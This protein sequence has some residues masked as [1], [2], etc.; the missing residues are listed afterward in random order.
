MQYASILQRLIHQRMDIGLMQ[1]QNTSRQLLNGLCKNFVNLACCPSA[2]EKSHTKVFTPILV[3]WL[4]CIGRC[5]FVII[6]I[7]SLFVCLYTKKLYEKIFQ[8]KSHTNS[9][10]RRAPQRN[11]VWIIW[12]WRRKW[13]K[14]SSRMTID[15]L[16]TNCVV[17]GI[18]GRRSI[19]Y[20]YS[21]MC[22]FVL[23][24]SPGVHFDQDDDKHGQDE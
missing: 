7:W 14:G 15:F 9:T 23:R 2:S 3:L 20:V 17:S 13:S 4:F 21:S 12:S 10:T 24:V 11:K 18:R 19:S 6:L 22:T 8:K 16:K 1:A 5:I